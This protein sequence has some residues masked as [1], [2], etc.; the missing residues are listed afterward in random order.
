MKFYLV[1][2][3]IVI[4]LIFPSRYSAQVADSDFNEFIAATKDSI[5]SNP[6]FV[7]DQL[8]SYRQKN[9]SEL[10]CN[11]LAFT[12]R[13]HGLTLSRYNKYDEARLQYLKANSIFEKC[14]IGNQEEYSKS[15]YNI[16]RDYE[17]LNEIQSAKKYFELYF[18]IAEGAE[19]PPNKY[20]SKI[21]GYS[22]FLSHKLGDIE[23]SN[24][25]KEKAI[26]TVSTLPNNELYTASIYL[27]HA[28]N[29]LAIEKWDSAIENA[30][31]SNLIFIE[32]MQD[33]HGSFIDNK[34]N[35]ANA[36]YRKGFKDKME[37]ELNDLEEL[38]S[39]FDT[40]R[41][42]INYKNLQGLLLLAK[43]VRF[44]EVVE[45]YDEILTDKEAQK[46]EDLIIA[47]HNNKGIALSHIGKYSEAHASFDE[48]FKILTKNTS[49]SLD[50]LNQQEFISSVNPIIELY[51]FKSEAYKT[52]YQTTKNATALEKATEIYKIVE[53][54]FQNKS[55]LITSDIN[56][57]ELVD[58]IKPNYEGAVKTHL[59]FEEL[60]PGTTH[61]NA[62]YH[63]ASSIKGIVL[64]EGS[65]AHTALYQTLP[66][67][68]LEQER[69]LSK[70]LV[71]QQN[72]IA[73]TA[74][75]ALKDS[76]LNNYLESKNTYGDFIKQL[77]SKYSDYHTLKYEKTE[78]LELNKI[79]SLIKPNEL[80]LDYYFTEDTLIC[81]SVSK[82]KISVTQHS[83]DDAFKNS[84]SDNRKYT[85]E[86]TQGN[87]ANDS[88]YLTLIESNITLH[89]KKEKLIIIPDED[90]L[91]I[92]FE[93]LEKEGKNLLADYAVSYLFLNN[94]IEKEKSKNAANPYTGFGTQYSEN[95]NEN[96]KDKIDASNLP[97]SR[98]AK[99]SKE[100][101]NA[102]TTWNGKVYTNSD[103]T[104][105]N[106]L[107]NASK[108]NILH[109]ALH[110][111][112]DN[113]S[114]DQSA[115]I[116]DDREKDNILKTNELYQLKLDNQLTI[117]TAC[118]SGN[119]QLFQGEG[120]RSLAR[121]FAFA[122]CPS[123][124]SSMWSA[125]DGPTNEIISSFNKYL[126]EG[127][128]KSFALRQAKLD[129]LE[130][131]TPSQKHPQYWANLILV[132]DTSPIEQSSFNPLY[133]GIGV[134]VLLL[135][136][137]LFRKKR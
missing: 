70:N 97:L 39:N 109:F 98:L 56:K 113:E 35:I 9:E 51:K 13:T 68:I 3:F 33:Y 64:K 74:D 76:L 119:G 126:S 107:E 134:L 128:D 104:K 43:E 25:Y 87:S 99:A 86:N 34:I 53:N 105:K 135:V 73:L 95:L 136:Y 5:R 63:Y 58:N 81:F 117:L 46:Y 92:S 55:T 72:T 11:Q 67:S 90:L 137:F 14:E 69:S 111:I 75:S 84:I 50:K 77:E 89:P 133:L 88:L 47:A 62:A 120:I 49:G 114:F 29:L 10:N 42:Y 2:T 23:S 15:M 30:Q 85:E 118:N 21:M 110:G 93:S 94:Q 82:E 18:Q 57:L 125:A 22:K 28:R 12:Y 36:F 124:V 4:V 40:R 112:I 32:N 71:T 31:K 48:S 121:G 1:P 17:S 8:E 106:F 96:L 19:I 115:L 45:I 24:I 122:G 16:A 103:A 127:M 79:Q 44:E 26:S 6:E 66:E 65:N 129:Y 27:A 100:I 123:I 131:A 108:S 59:K 80:V 91:K 41:G 54:I 130:N 116:F 52:E 7:Y 20:Y 60:N 102:N 61:L 83:I 101:E 38:Y 132:G 78:P 37:N